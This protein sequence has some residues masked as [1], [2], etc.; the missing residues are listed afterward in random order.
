M[1]DVT[2]FRNPSH[3]ASTAASDLTT[4]LETGQSGVDGDRPV[5]LM[6]LFLKPN[7]LFGLHAHPTI[8]LELTLRGALGE[9]RLVS[10]T[11]DV[12]LQI[13]YRGPWPEREGGKSLHGPSLKTLTER[14]YAPLS[15]TAQ[16]QKTEPVFPG[17][18]LFNEVGSIH[19][20]YT[21]DGPPFAGLI[22]WGGIHATI[23]EADEGVLIPNS[24]LLRM[25]L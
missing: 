22:L 18:Y 15:H 10:A 16:W 17:N 20:S 1:R 21:E 8:E 9:V 14:H 3:L 7:Q 19:K 5:K 25:Q 24:E 4:F 13:P 12:P 11:S 2:T 6:V 23:D